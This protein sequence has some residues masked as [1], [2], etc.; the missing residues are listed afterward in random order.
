MCRARTSA[1]HPQW[2]CAEGG[3]FLTDNSGLAACGFGRGGRQSRGQ[4]QEE[5]QRVSCVFHM[6]YGPLEMPFRSESVISPPAPS[7]I[8][9]VS[10]I[11]FPA[12]R[13]WHSL[14]LLGL[15]SGF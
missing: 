2:A 10:P 12:A 3:V 8:F 13:S 11:F 15:A 7:G 9:H 4:S 14:K 1:Y 6:T 5:Q